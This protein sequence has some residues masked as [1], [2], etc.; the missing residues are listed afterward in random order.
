MGCHHPGAR[1]GFNLDMSRAHDDRVVIE[2]A[3]ELLE[4]AQ[5]GDG[6]ARAGLL[7][8]LHAAL[9]EELDSGQTASTGR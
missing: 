5:Q 4:T 3:I 9:E 6:E 2:D 7:E 1:F 8:A